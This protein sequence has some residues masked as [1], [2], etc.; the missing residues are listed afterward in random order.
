MRTRGMAINNQQ[1]SEVSLLDN[2]WDQEN[3]ISLLND[4]FFIK[5]NILGLTLFTTAFIDYKLKV[6]QGSHHGLLAYFKVTAINSNLCIGE[7][8][9]E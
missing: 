6:V 1:D 3:N 4:P 7:Y 5:A 2:K 8:S 9:A